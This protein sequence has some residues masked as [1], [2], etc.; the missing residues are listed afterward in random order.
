MDDQ[1]GHWEEQH[2]AQ[3]AGKYLRRKGPSALP[4][5]VCAVVGL[6][7][8]KW[9]H[10]LPKWRFADSPEM[11]VHSHAHVLTLLGSGPGWFEGSRSPQQPGAYCYS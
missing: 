8:G 10:V 11:H 2:V 5:I 7:P 1:P 6:S 4:D 3:G 9:F